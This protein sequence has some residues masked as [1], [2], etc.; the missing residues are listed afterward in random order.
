MRQVIEPI[1]VPDKHFGDRTSHPAFGVISAS[2]VSGKRELFG[3]HVGHSGYIK[4]TIRHAEVSG[5]NTPHEHVSGRG[6]VTEVDMSEAQWVALISRMNHGSGVPCTIEFTEK[7]GTVAEIK[8]V[9]KA[10]ERLDKQAESMHEKLIERDA[11]A[12]YTVRKAIEERVPQKQRVEV[13]RYLDILVSESKRTTDYYKKVLKEEAEKLTT[14]ARIEIDAM[15]NG[16]IN[17]LGLESAQQLGAILAADPKKAI[18]L[19]ADQSKKDEP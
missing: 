14:E 19:I 9:D 6:Y 13:L 5:Y 8:H 12:L 3:S 16:A 15:L 2:R 10:A 18:L 17:N 1:T 4:L 11:Q 7:L